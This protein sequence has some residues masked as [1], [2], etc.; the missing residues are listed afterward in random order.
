MI[1]YSDTNNV[2]KV[3]YCTFVAEVRVQANS[4]QDISND[5]FSV[6]LISVTDYEFPKIISRKRMV[7]KFSSDSS[8]KVGEEETPSLVG[9]L[10]TPPGREPFDFPLLFYI[11]TSADTGSVGYNYHI[12]KHF[13]LTVENINGSDEPAI[14][15]NFIFDN[16]TGEDIQVFDV[17]EHP[18]WNAIGLSVLKNY[19]IYLDIRNG[20]VKIGKHE[21]VI[22]KESEETFQVIFKQETTDKSLSFPDDL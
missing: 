13:I 2:S 17:D 7:Q 4:L 20:K 5:P 3:V 21:D 15:C 1:L 16:I 11:D 19:R 12:I 10:Q 18:K 6:V 8:C 22:E 14:L 9:T